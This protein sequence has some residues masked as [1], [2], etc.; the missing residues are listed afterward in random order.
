MD[1][2]MTDIIMNAEFGQI[3]KKTVVVSFKS[4]LPAYSELG[5]LT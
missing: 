4:V 1:F 2:R 5:H 3:S